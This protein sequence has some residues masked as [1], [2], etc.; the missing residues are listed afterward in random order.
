VAHWDCGHYRLSV[1]CRELQQG[2]DVDDM[3][4]ALRAEA[5]AGGKNVWLS[6]VGT[7]AGAG[8]AL[9]HA[10]PPPCHFDVDLEPE[11]T[12]EGVHLFVA[13]FGSRRRNPAWSTR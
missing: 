5:P 13:Q 10:P 6:T 7:L 9:Y 1:F 8:F 11:L 2:Q 12:A 4:Q 3:L